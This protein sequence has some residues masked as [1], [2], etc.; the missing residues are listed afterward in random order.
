[1]GEYVVLAVIYMVQG[2]THIGIPPQGRT[3]NF[4]E[5]ERGFKQRCT[6]GGGGA[7]YGPVPT[8]QVQG[9]GTSGPNTKSP[10]FD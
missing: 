6:A 3:Q 2:Y 5:G 4:V 9:V 7:K 10:K 8:I 1:M